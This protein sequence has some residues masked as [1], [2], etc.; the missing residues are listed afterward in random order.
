MSIALDVMVFAIIAVTAFIGYKRGFIRY[1]IKM[2]GTIACVIVALI[3]SDMASG[4]VYNNIVAPRI[5]SSFNGRLQDFDIAQ[6]I[7][8]ALKEMGTDIPLDDKQFRK[9]LSDAG[10]I[11]AA[12]ERTLLSAGAD[13]KNAAS[14][15]EKVESFFDKDFV[16]EAAE[17]A[18]FDDHEGIGERLELTAGK[19]YDLVRA[20]AKDN[21]EGIHYL[22]YNI[23]DGILTT[24]IRYVLF[25]VI[26]IICEIILALVFR[27]AGVLDHL[28]AVSG[29]NRVLGLAAGVLKGVLYVGLIAAICSAV[30]KSDVIIDPK[31]FQSSHVF[32]LFFDFFYK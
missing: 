7:R 31:D 25:A 30:V 20:F 14:L 12:L 2:L 1:M 17:A 26:L 22:V 28:P 19:A 32:S 6:E 9:V 21:K 13:P 5:E 3:V 8:A 23:L 24:F 15:K 16:R 29:T 11:P 27:I 4:P 18:G 10:S